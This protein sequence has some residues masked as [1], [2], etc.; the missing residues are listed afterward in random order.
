MEENWNQ[1]LSRATQPETLVMEKFVCGS[2]EEWVSVK[3]NPCLPQQE[4]SNNN[5]NYVTIKS[6]N[7]SCIY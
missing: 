2:D 6:N 3:L 7:I 5:N 4:V 1:Y